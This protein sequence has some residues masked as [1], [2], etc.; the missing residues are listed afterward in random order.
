MST[1]L[2]ERPRPVVL[3]SRRP[4][5]MWRT[6]VYFD[7]GDEQ[8]EHHMR[9]AVKHLAAVDALVTFRVATREAIPMPLLE[10]S[11]AFGWRTA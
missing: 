11:H 9:E 1:Q 8:A 7:A 6:V 2:Q 10:H 5:G 3:Q 4:M